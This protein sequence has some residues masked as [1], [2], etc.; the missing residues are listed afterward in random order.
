[1]HTHTHTQTHTR[2]HTHKHIHMHAMMHRH[3]STSTYATISTSDFASTSAYVTHV[4]HRLFPMMPA[5]DLVDA[6]K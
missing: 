2:K 3:R 6:W 1:M 5:S 4:P